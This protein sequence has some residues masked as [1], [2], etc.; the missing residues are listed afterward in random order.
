MNLLHYCII[1]L[2]WKTHLGKPLFG[3]IPINNTDSLFTSSMV[4]IQKN[5]T[6][7]CG[8]YLLNEEWIITA[9]HCVHKG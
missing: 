1:F 6:H 4:S 2:I 7:I 3:G 8:G 9:A 5:G